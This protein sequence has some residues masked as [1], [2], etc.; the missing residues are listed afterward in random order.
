MDRDDIMYLLEL[1]GRLDK[2]DEESESFTLV[3]QSFVGILDA[4]NLLIR[5]LDN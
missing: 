3:F 1:T 4:L 2:R 5:T